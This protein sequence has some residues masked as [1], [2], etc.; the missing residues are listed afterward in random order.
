[1]TN[2]Q[3]SYILSENNVPM[4]TWVTL[5]GIFDRIQLHS[6]GH[7][8]VSPKTLLFYFDTDVLYLKRLSGNLIPYNSIVQGTGYI[9]EDI[10]GRQYLNGV[11]EYGIETNDKNIGKI[12]EV[13][14][15][16]NITAF[17]KNTKARAAYN[18]ITLRT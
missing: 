14:D 3:I 8:T 5:Y 12:H 15:S 9:I 6:D 10:N 18:G 13:V 17:I 1:M 16:T 2:A 7:I 4:K 11:A